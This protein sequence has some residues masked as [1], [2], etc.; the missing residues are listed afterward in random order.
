MLISSG[1]TL[2]HTNTFAILE[3]LII[4]VKSFQGPTN[5]HSLQT[6]FLPAALQEL[7]LTIVDFPH[8]GQSKITKLSFAFTSILQLVHLIF[9]YSFHFLNTFISPC[10]LAWIEPRLAVF[11]E[12]PVARVRIPAG[13]L[14]KLKS[15]TGKNS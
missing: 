8:L 2:K 1:S 4:A 11:S 7:H 3:I 10:S 14:L 5:P 12:K 6:Y 9:L 15:I 13:A